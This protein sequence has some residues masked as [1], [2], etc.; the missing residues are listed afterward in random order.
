MHTFIRH[1][2]TDHLYF[3]FLCRDRS[4]Y[5][6][7]N[8]IFSFRYLFRCDEFNLAALSVFVLFTFRSSAALYFITFPVSSVRLK[9]WL[10]A[11]P[12][13]YLIFAGKLNVI[14]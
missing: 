6:A 1:I 13:S 14:M 2:F 7:C 12:V 8:A 5:G 11:V 9:L 4:W 10:C 3:V